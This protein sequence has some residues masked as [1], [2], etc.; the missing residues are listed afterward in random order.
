MGFT[1][2]CFG[3][4]PPSYQEQIC[5]QLGGFTD[6]KISGCKL[7]MFPEF[8]GSSGRHIIICLCY[9]VVQY[10]SDS[11]FPSVNN[12]FWEKISETQGFVNSYIM[13][14]NIFRMSSKMRSELEQRGQ[15][16]DTIGNENSF[17]LSL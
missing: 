15:V 12:F 8:G 9:C 17:H 3:S 2:S 7:L 14:I 10:F 16:H 6:A 5:K 11:I 1:S 4:K 13:N